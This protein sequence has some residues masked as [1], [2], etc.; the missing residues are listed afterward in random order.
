MTD[1]NWEKELAKIDKQMESVSDEALFPTRNVPAASPQKQERVE[2]QAQTR[3]W[4]ALARLAL[5][6]ILGVAILF[7]PYVNRCGVGLAAY[8]IAV[9]AVGVG[10]VWSAV[11][12]WKHRTAG[13]HMLS[14]LLVLWGLILTAIEVLPRVGYAT[15]TLAHPPIWTCG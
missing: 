12:T 15:P 9:T 10:G 6:V 5:S 1:R 3:S 8:L 7:W 4:G 13:A 14:L 11:W 2:A